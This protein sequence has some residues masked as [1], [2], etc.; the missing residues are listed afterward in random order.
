M[1]N[2]N[3]CRY[4]KVL[5]IDDKELDLFIVKKLVHL[6]SFADEVAMSTSA[7][8]A[9]SYLKTIKNPDEFPQLI[10]L[11][12]HMP[13]INGFEFLPL[14]DELPDRLKENCRIVMFS[15]SFD[16]RGYKKVQNHKHVHCFIDKPLTKEKLN[17]ISSAAPLRLSA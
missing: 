10:F 7:S 13:E 4:R 2:N 3:P 8:D 14:F 17:L 11:D 9:L 1:T 6:T 16:R 5:V 12:I 15:S